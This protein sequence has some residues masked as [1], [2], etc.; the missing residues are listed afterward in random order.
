MKSLAIKDC[1]GFIEFARAKVQT[2][3]LLLILKEYSEHRDDAGGVAVRSWYQNMSEDKSY[4]DA[5][6]GMSPRFHPGIE[7]IVIGSIESS[8]LDYALTDMNNIL[9]LS[10]SEEAMAENLT[11]LVNKY[12]YG[13]ST[14]FICD[15][16]LMRE[17]ER[18]M[19]R[20]RTEEAYEIIFE[21][22][23]E[24]FFIHKYLGP[25]AVKYIEP[26]HSKVYATLLFKMKELSA[27]GN[28]LN[29]VN[30]SYSVQKKQDT[31]FTLTADDSSLTL[32]FH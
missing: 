26:C 30:T 25:K 7:Q 32:T 3:G 13:W 20:A 16:C 15:G 28:P 9:K 27:S 5:I 17:L 21:Q 11:R 23:G 6:T 1:V 12:T 19:R 22:D 4:R 8:C 2:V 18:I 10:M 31:V 14:E 24:N 29:I